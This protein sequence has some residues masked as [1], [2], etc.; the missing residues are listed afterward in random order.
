MLLTREGRDHFID[1]G[2][3]FWRALSF[4]EAAQSFDIIE[5]PGTPK[6][7]AMPWAGSTTS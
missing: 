4:I 2:G 5:I 6:K 3:S 7:W 1:S